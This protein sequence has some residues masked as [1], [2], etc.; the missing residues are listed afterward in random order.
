VSR[1]IITALLFILCSSFTTLAGGV[2][3]IKEVVNKSSKAVRVSA[4]DN[5]TLAENGL[6]NL[7]TTSVIAAGADWRGDM[8]VPWADNRKQFR[9]HFITMEIFSGSPATL[10]P[11]RVFGVYQTGEEI[12]SSL[13]RDRSGNQAEVHYLLEEEYNATAPRIDGEWKSGGD[14]RVIFFDRADGSV[15]F[16]LERYGR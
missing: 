6:R 8:W 2:T 7:I 14:R 9:S 3:N 15:G 16:K 4:Y 5:K 12:R 1:K 13:V 11:V 10:G